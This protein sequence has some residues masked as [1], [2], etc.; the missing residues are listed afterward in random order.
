MTIEEVVGSVFDDQAGVLVHQCN[1]ITRKGKHLSAAVFEKYPHANIYARRSHE[2]GKRDALGVPII[3]GDGQQHRWVANFVAQRYPGSSKYSNDTPTQRL[4]W[5]QQCLRVFEVWLEQHPEVVRV[6]F[7]H[8]IGCGAAGGDWTSY[9]NAIRV[10]ATRVSEKVNVIVCRLRQHP[11]VDR[12]T[13]P[14]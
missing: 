11:E 9:F 10:F 1:S 14:I 13:F 6:V 7:P 8:G 3:L 12:G 2:G 4:Q 5:F